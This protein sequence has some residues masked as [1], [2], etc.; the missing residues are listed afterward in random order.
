[1]WHD[2]NGQ[3]SPNLTVTARYAKHE[4]HSPRRD[5]CGI[6][7]S[8]SDASIIEIYRDYRIKANRLGL[9]TLLSGSITGVLSGVNGNGVGD[10]VTVFDL[11][12]VSH[13]LRVELVEGV[14][15]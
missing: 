13:A 4:A 2:D 14:E 12:A 8:L 3:P 15:L 10:G 1:M 5:P 7:D 9:Y 6:A 11:G